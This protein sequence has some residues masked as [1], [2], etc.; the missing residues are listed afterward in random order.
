MRGSGFEGWIGMCGWSCV[1]F[2]GGRLH[3]QAPGTDDRSR[4]SMTVLSDHVEYVIS[5][6]EPG[7]VRAC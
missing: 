1:A 3:G 5:T 7:S 4:V 6:C 2:G